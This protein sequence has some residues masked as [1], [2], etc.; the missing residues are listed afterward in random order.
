MKKN[1]KKGEPLEKS[2]KEV[3]YT[4]LRNRE[5]KKTG[6]SKAFPNSSGKS[7]AM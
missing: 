7:K 2:T 1:V 4:R 6:G 5:A 3:F